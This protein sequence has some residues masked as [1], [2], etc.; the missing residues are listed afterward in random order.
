MAH[1]G[2]L[3]ALESVRNE[4]AERLPSPQNIRASGGYINDI[5]LMLCRF[6]SLV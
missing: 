6:G 1:V 4:E 2:A 3:E 5:Y